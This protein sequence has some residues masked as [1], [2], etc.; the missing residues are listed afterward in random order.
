MT[1]SST[2]FA[3]G[4]TISGQV[5]P[6]EYTSQY[7]P[8]L[9]DR[10]DDLIDWD[11]RKASENNFFVELLKEAESRRVLDA[12]AGTGFHSVSLAEAGFEVTAV[13]GSRKMLD[14]AAA[15]ARREGQSFEIIHTDWRGLGENLDGRYD[16]IVCLGSSFP[17]L[18]DEADRR[19]VLAEFYEAL[20]PGG[21][22]ILDHRNFD[23]IR[24]HRYRSSGNFYY[25]GTGANVSVAHID[26]NLCRFRYDFPDGATYHLEVYPVLKDELTGLLLQSGFDTTQTFGDFQEKFDIFAS[27][28]IIHVARKA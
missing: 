22:L 8:T 5:A 12:A 18:F 25:C 19:A 28:F 9:V 13:D 11:R 3:G 21:M 2:D 23:A 17:H 14:R 20:N 15:N 4:T 1:E 10:W 6:E 24:A 7:K 26:E 27:D 16:A